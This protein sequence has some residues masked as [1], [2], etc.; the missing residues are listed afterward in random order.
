MELPRKV[1][2]LEETWGCDNWAYDEAF[3]TPHQGLSQFTRR[4]SISLKLILPKTHLKLDSFWWGDAI[5]WVVWAGIDFK[6]AWLKSDK[7]K[8]LATDRKEQL[9]VCELF[10]V[11]TIWYLHSTLLLL[12]CN[13][14]RFQSPHC[15]L[16]TKIEA[17]STLKTVNTGGFHFAFK[18]KHDA[19][20]LQSAH[21]CE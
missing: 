6:P 12:L 21:D 9:F 1:F 11:S 15:C 13:Y 16:L 18:N 7:Y 10:A 4:G 5:I 14:G 17:L 2:L 20:N 3:A 19:R 8:S